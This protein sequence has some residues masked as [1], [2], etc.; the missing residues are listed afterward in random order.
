MESKK[1]KKIAAKEAKVIF[2]NDFFRTYNFDNST[3]Q[4]AIITNESIIDLINRK[5]TLKLDA[6]IKILKIAQ[7]CEVIDKEMIKEHLWIQDEAEDIMWN[8]CV[9]QDEVF[10]CGNMVYVKKYIN[11]YKKFVKSLYLSQKAK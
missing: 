11:E 4:D 5:N 7:I 2:T 8:F 10:L 1:I 6:A 3:A 9:T